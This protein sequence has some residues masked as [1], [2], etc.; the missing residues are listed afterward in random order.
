MQTVGEGGEATNAP[1]RAPVRG[2][3][4]ASSKL[5]RGAAI[6]LTLI[7][8][9][10]AGPGA[11]LADDTKTIRY[12]GFS[13]PRVLD[14]VAN[15]LAVTLQH[16]YLVYD[17]LFSRD[18]DGVAQPQ[19]VESWEVSDDFKRYV[20]V[21]REDLRFHDGSPVEAEDV[22]ASINRW[23]QRD[24]SGKTLLSFGMALAAL[25]NRTVELTL[26]V[27]TTIV[28]DAFAKPTAAPLFVMR[29][30]EAANAPTE[31]VSEIIGSGPFIFVRE[32]H[33]P[34]SR[35]VYRRNPDYVPRDEPASYLSGGKVAKVDRVEW[36][37]LPDAGSSINALLAGEVDVLERPPLDLLPILEASPDVAL[38]IGNKQG[39]MGYIRLNHTQQIFDQ[40]EGREA[41]AYLVDQGEYMRSVAGV[42][43]KYWRPCYSFFACGGRFESEAGMED[44]MQSDPE[45][46]RE[47]L[48]AAGYD[49]QMVAVLG[50]TDST[51]LREFSVLT[52]ERLKSIGVNVDLRMTDIAS[53]LASRSNRGLPDDGGWSMFHMTSFGFEL[54]DPIGNFWLDSRCEEN[55]YA[56]WPCDARMEELRSAWARELDPAKQKEIAR[57]I[58]EQAALNF[59]IVPVGQFFYPVAFR[60]SVSDLPKAPLTVFW[61]AD[62]Q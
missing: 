54:D 1:R 34:G 4:L 29:R 11:A 49:G 25:D 44:R 38:Q 8:G 17:T 39:T 50:V 30:Q 36:M 61:N 24:S 27:P 16:G 2:G 47:L 21:L 46:A 15:W 42:D 55:I 10:A 37:V 43:D 18:A 3:R 28:V 9:L 13:E 45:K 60:T 12:V 58:Q 56:G 48:A 26:E 22:V 5:I 20:F 31:P 52:A 19:M 53:M 33:V 32:E 14:P 57:E 59:P 40:P 7:A 62:K 6:G 35:L 23:A 51:V 41:M